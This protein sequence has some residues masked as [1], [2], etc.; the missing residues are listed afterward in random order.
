MSRRDIIFHEKFEQSVPRHIV[1]EERNKSA[2][3]QSD[4]GTNRKGEIDKNEDN[5]EKPE[6][7]KSKNPR[8]PIP[9][10]PYPL[11]RGSRLTNENEEVIIAELFM[12]QVD[13]PH[14]EDAL[15][16]E[17]SRKWQEAINEELNSLKENKTRV[18]VPRPKH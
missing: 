4:E 11:R 12:S 18:L 2:N 16:A 10:D 9:R 15:K 14:L 13:P 7:T 3:V 5:I 6:K 8:L 1:V 17:N